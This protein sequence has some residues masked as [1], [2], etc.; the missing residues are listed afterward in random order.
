MCYCGVKTD[1]YTTD[2]NIYLLIFA[3]NIPVFK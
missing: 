2:V 3:W 1:A